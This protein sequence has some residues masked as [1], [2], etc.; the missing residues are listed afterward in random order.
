MGPLVMSLCSSRT[1]VNSIKDQC[2]HGYLSEA[3]QA[4]SLA[5]PIGFKTIVSSQ[6]LPVISVGYVRPRNRMTES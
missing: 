5:A 2:V 4:L 1:D 6:K 3:V